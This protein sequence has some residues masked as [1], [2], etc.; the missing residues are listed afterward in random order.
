MNLDYIL[1]SYI[2]TQM[3][4]LCKKKKEKRSKLP[5]NFVLLVDFIPPLINLTNISSH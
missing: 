2:A 5:L 4:I 1:T 3:Y